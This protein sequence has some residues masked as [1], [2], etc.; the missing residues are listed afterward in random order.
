[1]AEPGGKIPTID[2][3]T[4]S[5]QL[6]L[7]KALAGAAEKYARA[8]RQLNESV[9]PIAAKMK[10]ITEAGNEVNQ[11]SLD[12]LNEQIE[13]TGEQA[14]KTTAHMSKFE[15]V[16]ASKWTKAAFVATTALTGFWQ[17][18]RNIGAIGKS[19]L[20]FLSGAVSWV[21][22]LGLSILAIPL[23]IFKTF[24]DMAAGLEGGTELMQ[25][26]ENIRKQFGDLHKYGAKAVMDTA[27][28]LKGFSD[29][30]LSAWRVFG[31]LAERLDKVREVAT[32]MG[33]TFSLV[34]KEFQA[35]GGAILGYQKGL[36][37][38]DE[39]MK[40]LTQRAITMG[41]MIG[42]QMN[43]IAKQSL[44]LGKSFGLDQ[45]L[46]ARS[47][48]K[49]V[50]DIKHFGQMTIK[51]I[52]TAAVYARKLGVELDKIVGT[53]D[54]FET[55]DQAAE[56]AA[57]LTQTFGVQIDALKMMEAQDPAQQIEDLR[58]S[59]KN[60]GVSS[61]SF[62]RQQ[63]KLLATQTGLDEETA[64]MVFSS[65]N[66]GTSYEDIKKKSE[67]AQ[68]AQ[69]TQA[70][71][72]SKLA[73]SIERMVKAGGQL[74]GSFFKMFMKGF[75]D[76]IFMSREFMGIMLN[77]R[78]ALYTVYAEG[79][80]LGKMFVEL[81][82][83]L[84]D[85]L[86]GVRE[87]FEPGKF[88]TLT[89][90]IVDVFIDFMKK[91]QTGQWSFKELMKNI[92]EK[93][94]DF[95]NKEMPAGKKMI[96]GF[97]TM[98]TTIRNVVAEGIKWLGERVAE[99]IKSF[100]DFVA[101]PEKAIEGGKGA[102]SF[103]ASFFGP[104]AKA[105][106][107]A[108]GVMWPEIEKLL[109]FLF[110]KI[111]K[112]VQSDA[113]KSKLKEVFPTLALAMFGPAV[114]RGA[115]AG[116]TA[117]LAPK[118]G[119]LFTSKKITDTI[120]AA[121]KQLANSVPDAKGVGAA[122]GAV[123]GLGGVV[124][125][126]GIQSK[127]ASKTT[128]KDIGLLA[129]KILAV[130]GALGV[131]GIF[132]A[133]SVREMN[134]VLPD[135]G[136]TLKCMIVIGAALAGIAVASISA[137]AISNN[138][139]FAV[140]I[141]LMATS[142]ALGAGGVAISVAIHAMSKILPDASEVT[143]VILTL[144][145]VM[146]AMVPLLLT[147]KMIKLGDVGK[148]AAGMAVIALAVV[149]LGAVTRALAWLMEEAGPPEQLKATGDIMWSMAKVFLA[150]VPVVAA[151]MV[152]GLVVIKSMGIA[153]GA[154][155]AGLAVL[156]TTVVAVTGTAI[157]IMEQL[158]DMPTGTG[159]QTK[160]DAFLGIMKAIQAFS[161]T[162]VKIID[163][164][165]PSF[166]DLFTGGESFTQKT[167]AAAGLIKTMVGTKGSGTGI[168][169]VVETVM[170]SIKQLDIGGPAMAESAKIFTD[171]MTGIAEF[172][173]AA[174][175]PDSFF[176]AG[177]SFINK[178]A[179]PTYDFQSVAFGV[180]QYTDNM[181]EGTMQMLTGDPKGNGDGGILAIIKT[182]AKTEVPN[183][184]KASV[185][186][187]L[188]SAVGQVLKTLTPSADVLQAFSKNVDVES[189]WG[190]M[191]AKSSEIDA[192]AIAKT[193]STMGE[194]MKTILPVLLDSTLTTIVNKTKSLTKDQLEGIKTIAPIMSSMSQIASSFVGLARG[195]KTTPQQMKDAVV[196]TVEEAPNL[197]ELFDGIG[198]VMPKL[199][200]ST[201][202]A[203]EGIK[204]GKN[205]AEQ[206]KNAEQLFGFIKT[207]S[208]LAGNLAGGGS[209]QMI[210]PQSM[211]FAMQK[212]AW[213]MWAIVEG[214][215][216]MGRGQYGVPGDSPLQLIVNDLMTKDVFKKL[217][218]AKNI[219]VKSAEGL[220][221][222]M[223]ATSNIVSSMSTISEG[224]QLD[225][226]ALK[227]SLDN[228]SSALSSISVKGGPI[229]KMIENFN[230]DAI[231]RMK[232]GA[233]QLTSFAESLKTINDTITKGALAVSLNAAADICKS[234]SALD[235]ALND[236]I[237]IDTP[238]KLKALANKAGL[239]SKQNYTI[240]NKGVQINI[241]LTVTMN[242]GEVEKIIVMRKESVIR[243]RLNF[244]IDNPT[245]KANAGPGTAIPESPD[246]FV[247][248]PLAKGSAT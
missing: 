189:M 206:A 127:L 209:G 3:K 113:V 121:S 11:V 8:A 198:D 173:R 36:G 241:A 243:D 17:G 88:R 26:I 213:F 234:A 224:K 238:T 168:I 95:F 105:I 6:E 200:E 40:Q 203:V 69:M 89:K 38:A 179:D 228:V 79:R 141:K 32:A 83:G 62:N 31:N 44:S 188:L 66:Q 230:A 34:Y 80:R 64:R 220:A 125:E 108:A 54:A 53:L 157:A 227:S 75:K 178:L 65:K 136:D 192:D 195:K 4:L 97:K 222:L 166:I 12:N 133:L 132:L 207:M 165:T 73:D 122:R 2:E 68:K 216:G 221:G 210:D 163:L 144:A 185:V 106:K 103:V 25:A 101:H 56:N 159:F 46:I 135:L 233:T 72:L 183:P 109:L 226:V 201:I 138:A 47:M 215:G 22:K 118:L 204:L 248:N 116:L 9:S 156:T 154:V 82:P 182:L 191:K 71:A 214:G 74:E 13:K 170:S 110:E 167:T 242:A 236:G 142:L 10:E 162:I 237:K 92:R 67:A 231:G 91:L 18:L 212:L 49:A 19:V 51:E 37:I 29:T 119:E 78:R 229:D 20:G 84:K 194:Q 149:G 15:R 98:M 39:D 48:S 217:G 104:I 202:K 169:G 124:Q 112:F 99:G 187:N 219:A 211:V 94:L 85:F 96:D 147:S 43:D 115:F 86:A 58:R 130:A 137:R 117:A 57:K 148:M 42:E 196:W 21:T 30:G 111:L 146:L 197:K 208:E 193:I 246:G 123:S 158:R 176:E 14:Q 225:P 190:F 245:D 23:K 100:A 76:G 180:K 151:S 244:A 161:D 171:V 59:F 35:N 145:G 134:R 128:V 55:F 45:K 140:G 90:G 175:P 126:A 120:G 93:F 218:E 152:L 81:F 172:A 199:I 139:I 77:I 131:G 33:A 60:A 177:S 114:I 50:V 247:F 1:M 174:T 143:K 160:V 240:T 24:M 186:A 107:Y 232:L 153:A 7:M 184:E 28:Q 155:L 16:L 52:G 181:R 129:M 150:M 5:V 223:K 27:Y 63:L 205:F 235:D 102:V 61:E 87:F 164:T 41:T 70:Q 239:G